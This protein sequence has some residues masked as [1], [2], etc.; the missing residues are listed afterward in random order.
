MRQ[1]LLL[2]IHLSMKQLVWQTQDLFLGPYCCCCWIILSETV[3]DSESKHSPARGLLQSLNQITFIY[4]VIPSNRQTGGNHSE[5]KPIDVSVCI[6]GTLRIQIHWK[7]YILWHNSHLSLNFC[8]IKILNVG[9]PSFHLWHIFASWTSLTTF[10]HSSVPRPSSTLA[11]L[12]S[13]WTSEETFSPLFMVNFS[14]LSTKFR[15]LFSVKRQRLIGR[16]SEG[17]DISWS[18]QKSRSGK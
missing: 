1:H 3:I 18:F 8:L 6:S 16:H 5:W 10:S 17:D 7:M 13:P 11:T 12:S 15:Y 9:N 14:D 2:L 4:S